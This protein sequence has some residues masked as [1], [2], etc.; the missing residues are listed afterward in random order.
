MVEEKG[1]G[2]V[3]LK[4]LIYSSNEEKNQ[5]LFISPEQTVYTNNSLVTLLKSTNQM[6]PMKQSVT[7]VPL[8][9]FAVQT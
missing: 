6:I 3:S 2:S 4:P 9:V 7:L 1:D 5:K 8:V